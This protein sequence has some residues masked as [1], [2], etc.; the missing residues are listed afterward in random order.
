MIVKLYG[1]YVDFLD[2]SIK[3]AFSEVSTVCSVIK[4]KLPKPKPKP[5]KVP[6]IKFVQNKYE[7]KLVRPPSGPK[8]TS[9]YYSRAAQILEEK[10]KKNIDY[11][12]EIQRDIRQ[13]DKSYDNSS[14][15]LT[16]TFMTDQQVMSGCIHWIKPSNKNVVK[17]A[18]RII[19]ELS[20]FEGEDKPKPRRTRKP[21]SGGGRSKIA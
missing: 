18:A 15:A 17:R 2:S 19:D 10:P 14:Q 8:P 5:P 11:L 6:K 3:K 20:Y 9:T 13:I 1:K 12:N 21:K 16:G 7:Q 4:S